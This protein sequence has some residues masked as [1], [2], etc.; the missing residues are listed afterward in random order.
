MPRYYYDCSSCERGYYIYHGMSEDHIKC[1]HCGEET[2]HRV[3]QMAHI[4]RK[5]KSKG[6][7]VGDE[8]KSAIEENRAILDKAKK[9]AKNNQWEPNHDN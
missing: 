4:A 7:K 1:L 6:S 9:Q 8:V 3:P 5:N 2:I